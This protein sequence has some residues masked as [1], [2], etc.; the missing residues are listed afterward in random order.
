MN[1]VF[2]AG[3]LGYLTDFM[4]I[5]IGAVLAYFIYFLNKKNKGDIHIK[6]NILFSFVFEF[7]SGLMMAIVTFRLIPDALSKCSLLMT[8]CGIFFGLIFAHNATK[9][10]DIKN[11][12]LKMSF[13]ILVNLWLHN[14]PEGFALGSSVNS[15]ITVAFM[16][17]TAILIHNIPQGFLIALP[18]AGERIKKR[19]LLYLL[20]LSGIPTASGAV[21]GTLVG[22]IVPAFTGFI[23]SFTAGSLLYVLVFELSYEARKMY[24]RKIIE[25]AYILGLILGIFIT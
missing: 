4:G 9:L 12:N 8:L 3:I 14:I 6:K 20:L 18:T 19:F 21:L 25:S 10:A 23:L 1:N 24:G 11:K 2:I 13:I 15:S 5:G 17:F 22:D 16:F 7:S